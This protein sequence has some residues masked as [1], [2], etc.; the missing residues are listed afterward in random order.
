MTIGR[1][2]LHGSLNLHLLVRGDILSDRLRCTLH[3]FGRYVQIG[4]KF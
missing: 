4:E 3:S 1:V 2:Q